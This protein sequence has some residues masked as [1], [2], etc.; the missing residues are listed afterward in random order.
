MVLRDVHVLQARSSPDCP[1]L[2]P[3]SAVFSYMPRTQPFV[4]QRQRLSTVPMNG[5]GYIEILIYISS[6]PQL[7]LPTKIFS[8]HFYSSV[9]R[10]E[11]RLTHVWKI[12]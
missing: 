12:A 1:V 7:F 10:Q 9:R 4:C 3:F 2:L 6:H 8:C 5:L 11:H